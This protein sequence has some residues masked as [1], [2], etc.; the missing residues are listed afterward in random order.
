MGIAYFRCRVRLNLEKRPDAMYVVLLRRN[1]NSQQRKV[2]YLLTVQFWAYQ[3]ETNA[4]FYS[5][6]F[7]TI[8]VEMPTS[9][10]LCKIMP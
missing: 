8:Q 3:Y 2:K 4:I 10:T 1:Y 9:K 6:T 7:K 5:F